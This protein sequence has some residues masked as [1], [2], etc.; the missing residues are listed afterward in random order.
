MQPPNRIALHEERLVSLWERLVP[1][2]GIHTV[3]DLRRL[4]RVF[5][6]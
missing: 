5:L 6:S 4:S 3:R 2:L 1:M